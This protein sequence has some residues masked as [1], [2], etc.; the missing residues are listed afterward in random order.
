M[1]GQL[2]VALTLLAAQPHHERMLQCL[3]TAAASFPNDTEG[4]RKA[5]CI[6]TLERNDLR[7][8]AE[9]AIDDLSQPVPPP[10]IRVV[11]KSNPL[12]IASIAM[13]AVLL[14]LLAVGAAN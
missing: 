3:S 4:V 11:E 10:E 6:T 7:A 2:L 5:L 13:A 1:A 9:E 8:F 12:H 14:T